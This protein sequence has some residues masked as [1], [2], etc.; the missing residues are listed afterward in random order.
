MLTPDQLASLSAGFRWSTPPTPSKLFSPQARHLCQPWAP[1]GSHP[2]TC[3]A[4]LVRRRF[5][6]HPRLLQKNGADGEKHLLTMEEWNS[7]GETLPCKDIPRKLLERRTRKMMM[8][9]NTSPQ[10]DLKSPCFAGYRLIFVRVFSGRQTYSIWHRCSNKIINWVNL[11][12]QLPP[13]KK[14]YKQTNKHQP[15][16]CSSAPGL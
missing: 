8:L 15:Q 2:K 10:S 12:P 11:N 14:I 5:S 7:G 9:L 4:H 6:N 13:K 1:T 3:F 16:F